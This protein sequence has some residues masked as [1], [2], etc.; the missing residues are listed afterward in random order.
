MS[1]ENYI[2]NHYDF[3]STSRPDMIRIHCPFCGDTKFHG[4]INTS[5]NL[6]KCFKCHHSHKPDGEATTAFY[7]LRE[8]GYTN[9]QILSILADGDYASLGYNSS[10]QTLIEFLNEYFNK[11]ENNVESTTMMEL[12]CAHSIELPPCK[13]IMEDS[14]SV[15]GRLAYNYIKNRFENPDE[16]IYKYDLQYCYSGSYFG[17]IIV[18]VYEWKKL[19]WF[20]GRTFLPANRDPKYLGPSNE[21]KPIF[22]IDYVGKEAI[23]CEGVFDAM[24]LGEGAICA[25]GS[26][27]SKSQI[28]TLESMELTTLIIYY[29]WDRAGRYGARQICKQVKGFIPNVGIVLHADRDANSLGKE[30]AYSFLQDN[31]EWY[32]SETDIILSLGA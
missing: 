9:E 22:G 32:S 13:K 26:S 2:K 12:Q 1:F 21:T 14:D 28:K 4:Y 7:F 6:F 16:V 19:V 10:E 24:T 25:F 20:Q 18:P 27:L 30:A 23:L 3:K 11:A 5:K 29:D 15:I 31:I 8:C 17:Y